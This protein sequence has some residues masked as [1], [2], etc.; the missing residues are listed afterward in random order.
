M[1][2]PEVSI[3]LVYWAPVYRHIWYRLVHIHMYGL[4]HSTTL[5]NYTVITVVVKGVHSTENFMW[6]ALPWYRPKLWF[7][8]R[9]FQISLVVLMLL[10]KSFICSSTCDSDLS[11]VY[12]SAVPYFHLWFGI[13]VLHTASAHLWYI[14]ACLIRGW[15]TLKTN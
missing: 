14:L 7:A 15:Q 8:F 1:D 5:H 2:T 9:G 3:V 12:S 6:F 10:N 11:V 13:E 4:M